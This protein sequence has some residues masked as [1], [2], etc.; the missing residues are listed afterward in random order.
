VQRILWRLTALAA[1]T[2]AAS[3]VRAIASL[4]WRTT[5]HEEPPANPAARGVKW[6]DALIWAISVAVGAAVARVVAERGAATAW[7]AATGAPPPGL[8][9]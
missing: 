7:E 1:G 3:A 5:R 8:D 6:R 2:A 4:T 9:E